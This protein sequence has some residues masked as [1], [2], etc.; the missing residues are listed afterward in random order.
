MDNPDSSQC[1][2][3]AV[4]I[5]PL[6]TTELLIGCTDCIT[7]VPGEPQVQIGSHSFTFDYVFGSTGYPSS[8]IFEECVAPIVDALF[9]GYNGTV[10]AYGQTGSGKTYTMGTNY[11][12]EEHNGG[13]IPKVVETIFSR[14]AATR[15]STEF[16]IRVSFI[17]IFKEEVFDLLD[18]CTQ[19]FSRGDGVSLVKPTGPARAPIQIRETL[20]GGIT[21]AGVTEAEV[22]TKEEMASFL[23]RA[24]YGDGGDNI[25]RSKLL[26]V[27][28]AGSERA[29]RTGADG[30]RFREGNDL[31]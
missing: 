11:N 22:R 8:Q 6:V 14:I 26:L 29:K 20:N 28:L 17:E 16:L 15:D 19:T 25:L 2:R 4:N 23:L 9:H 1:V 3:V 27:D 30:L 7:V 21:L 5:R 31:Y 13:V 24:I 18:P 10:L 12:G